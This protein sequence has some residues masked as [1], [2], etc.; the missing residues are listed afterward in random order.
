MHA[1]IADCLCTKLALF[2]EKS[3]SLRTTLQQATYHQVNQSPAQA[4]LDV[5]LSS[6]LTFRAAFT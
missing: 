1:Q 2:V 3:A 5:H 4:A 6:S